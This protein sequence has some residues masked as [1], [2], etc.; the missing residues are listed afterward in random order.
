MTEGE[1]FDVTYAMARQ[2]YETRDARARGLSD[3]EVDTFYGCALCQSFATNSYLC[4]H[5]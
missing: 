3:E 4:H 1:D 5:A 2:R